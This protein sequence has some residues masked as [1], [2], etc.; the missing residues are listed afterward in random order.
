MDF[1]SLIQLLDYFKDEATCI[2]YYENIRWNGSAVCPS[3]GCEKTYKTNRGHKCANK[4]CYKKFTVKTGTIFENSKI[5]FRTWFAAIF[6][7][8]TSKKGISSVQ[9][10]VQLNITQKTAW[11]VLHRIREML[12][13]KAPKMLGENDMVE[14]D[15]AYI[16]GKEGNKH[17]AKRRSNENPHLKND[18]TPYQAK[19]AVVGIIERNGKVVLKHIPNATKSNMVAFIEKHVPS[20][21]KVY[22]DEAKV[23]NKIGKRY[24]HKTVTHS[25]GVYVAG[26]VHTNTIENFWSVLKRGIYG[27]YH[28]VSDKHLERYLDEFAGRFNTRDL[29]NQGKFERF[30]NDSESVLGYSNLTAV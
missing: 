28:Q 30:L 10:A 25:I 24:G 18:G 12:K 27:I 20:G 11:Y 7:C 23:Y 1:K 3:C 4:E 2:E 17:H 8:T 26:D 5:P 19:K 6:L 16:G 14:A 15:E 13:D 21:S 22:T 29:S 9:L